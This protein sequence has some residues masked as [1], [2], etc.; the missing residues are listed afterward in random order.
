MLSVARCKSGD[1]E[2]FAVACLI[3]GTIQGAPLAPAYHAFAYA[4]RDVDVCVLNLGGISNVTVLRRLAVGAEEAEV[5]AGF[6][7]GPANCLMDA[8]CQAR[9]VSKYRSESMR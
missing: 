8:W 6:D 2:H 1:Y 9:I 3:C 5:A 4:S 7:V